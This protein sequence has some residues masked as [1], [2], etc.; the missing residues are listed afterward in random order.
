MPVKSSRYANQ[1]IGIAQGRAISLGKAKN[2]RLTWGAFCKELEAPQRTQESFS[3][4]L[5]LPKEEQDKLKAVNGWLLGGE[6]EGD[7]RKKNQIKHRDLI[8]LDCD[9]ITADILEDIKLGT[10]PLCRFEFFAHTTRKHQA[11]SPRLR[12]FLLTTR[13]AL[14]DEYD[15]VARILAEMVDPSMDSID[16]VSFRLAQMMFRPSASRNQ[17]YLAWHNPGERVDPTEI[18]E[19][20]RLDWRDY[21]NLPYSEKRGQRR[22]TAE[23]AENPTTKHGPVGAFCRA[24]DVEAAIAEFLPEVYLP[25]DMA[26]SKPRYS[27]ALGTTSNGVVVEDDGLFIYSHHGSDPCGERLCNAFDMVRIHKFAHL[28]EKQ[29]ENVSPKDWPSYKA[30]VKWAEED[31]AVKGELLADRV[32]VDAMFDDLDEGD[33]DAQ[34]LRQDGDTDI[35]DEIADLLAPA[36]TDALPPPR[37]ARP[38]KPKKNWPQRLLEL[39]LDGTIKVTIPNVA[40]ILQNDPRLWGAIGRNDFSNKVAVRRSIKSKVAVIPPIIVQDSQNGDDWTDLHDATLLA[41]LESAA[42]A[43]KPGWGMKVTQTDMNRAILLIAQLQ[44][45]H[46]IQEY[47]ERLQWDGVPRLETFWIDYLGTP[48]TAYARETAKL[49]FLASVCRV[50]NP[51]H[52][53][54][55]VPIFQG[56]QGIRKSSLLKVLF[57]GWAGELT[58]HMASNKDAVEQMLGKQCLE[59]PELSNMRKSEVEDVKAFITFEEDRVRLSYDRRQSTFKRQC[60]LVGT[61]N[62]EEYL[63]DATGNRRFWPIRVLVEMID[64]DAVLAIRDQL[65]AEAH[66]LWR[67]EAIKA[68][69]YKNIRLILSPKATEEAYALQNTAREEDGAEATGAQIRAWLD[70]PVPLSQW[71]AGP[72]GVL[73][74]LDSMEGEPMV[75]RCVVTP[76]WAAVEGLGIGADRLGMNVMSD[77]TI[78]AA[79]Q[80]VKGWKKSGSRYDHP[81]YGMGRS[82]VRE[83]ATWQEITQGYR[84]VGRA[85]DPTGAGVPLSDSED[86]DDIL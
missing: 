51:G 61:T 81:T 58:A 25:G 19:S 38:Q 9:E 20:F 34:E 66:H 37:H 3:A 86:P 59:L 43:N 62:A 56:D 69:S 10:S 11:E 53:W 30:M 55:H 27:Y 44:R 84:I 57:G 49:F 80:R 26:G 64:T 7:R 14:P 70:K 23:R 18:L 39:N 22:K 28:D 60:V 71:Q 65:W 1:M 73:D 12:I 72:E 83:G 36:A 47:Y 35:D 63:K 50:Y 2:R 29:G 52:K 78:G 6:I 42:G 85:G 32:D 45:F 67:Q 76:R 24:Y 15:A 79:M 82:Y 54:D 75:L 4:F 68:G 48:D 41:M 74:D 40:T 17:E 13:P 33:E 31:D 5:K 16:D 21:R 77:R 46:P 8:T